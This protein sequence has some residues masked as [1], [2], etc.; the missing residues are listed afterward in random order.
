MTVIFCVMILPSRKHV[1]PF[2]SLKACFTYMLTFTQM[3][4]KI[5][6]RQTV[7]AE[8]HGTGSGHVK[9]KAVKEI[10]KEGTIM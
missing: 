2:L 9:A 8:S 5:E 1:M 4:A 3:T 6:G 7:S 10:E